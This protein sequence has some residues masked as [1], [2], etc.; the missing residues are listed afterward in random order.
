[1]LALVLDDIADAALPARA[2]RELVRRGF[3]VGLRPGTGVLRLD[4]PLT[5]E[6]RDLEQFLSTLED[7]LS[8]EVRP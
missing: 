5:I 8:Q 2:H 6:R 4:P 1:M 3:I 7:V